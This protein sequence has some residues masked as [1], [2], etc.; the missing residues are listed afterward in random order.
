M[1]QSMM[2]SGMNCHTSVNRFVRVLQ[3]SLK[4]LLVW[5]MLLHLSK[6]M[7]QQVF[8]GFLPANNYNSC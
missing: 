1:R 6:F 2:T 4:S 5:K 3:L 7:A 8:D